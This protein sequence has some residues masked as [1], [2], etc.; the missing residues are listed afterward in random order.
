MISNL[1]KYKKDLETLITEGT[2]LYYAMLQE[3]NPQQ[4]NDLLKKLLAG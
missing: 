4:V 2:Y 3:S 1:E